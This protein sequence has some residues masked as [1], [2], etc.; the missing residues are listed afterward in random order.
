MQLNDEILL[1]FHE[2]LSAADTVEGI[3]DWWLPRQR[4]EQ[5]KERIQKA[6]DEL[7]AQGLI[8]RINLI[9]GTVIYSN[10]ERT[11]SATH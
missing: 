9:D 1:Y 2:H 5:S 7:V 6:L 11:K 4:Y 8:K 3:M 10:G